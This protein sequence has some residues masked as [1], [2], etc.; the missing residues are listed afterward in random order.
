M[1]IEAMAKN[2]RHGKVFMKLLLTRD[3]GVRISTDLLQTAMATCNLQIANLLFSRLSHTANDSFA[4]TNSLGVEEVLKF[5]R[6]LEV[7]CTT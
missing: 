1:V 2:S 7:F 4:V 5:M 3:P 6:D